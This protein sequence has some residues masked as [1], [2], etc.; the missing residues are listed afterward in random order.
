MMS[1]LEDGKREGGKVQ[2]AVFLALAKALGVTPE[3]LLTGEERP[4]VRRPRP[5]ASDTKEE[6]A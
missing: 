6:A 2:A 1:L 5:A 4:R 3:Y